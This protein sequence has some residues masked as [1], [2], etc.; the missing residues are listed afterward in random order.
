V[1]TWIRLRGRFGLLLVSKRVRRLED[2]EAIEVAV[3][4]LLPKGSFRLAIEEAG[5]AVGFTLVRGDRWKLVSSISTL[6][7]PVSDECS[8]RNMCGSP[9]AVSGRKRATPEAIRLLRT[10]RIS[11]H[12]ARFPLDSH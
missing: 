1:Q 2:R 8:S 11:V 7:G 12:R 9:G 10:P 5:V 3:A 6:A 4:A